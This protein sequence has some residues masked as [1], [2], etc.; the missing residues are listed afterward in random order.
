[1]TTHAI[2]K[3]YHYTST[4]AYCNAMHAE[5]VKMIVGAVIPWWGRMVTSRQAG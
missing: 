1:M 3:L 2:A 5:S 4:F